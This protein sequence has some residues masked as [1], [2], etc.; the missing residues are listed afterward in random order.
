VVERDAVKEREEMMRKEAERKA[1]KTGSKMHAAPA[2]AAVKTKTGTPVVGASVT[3]AAPAV[4][5]SL[6]FTSKVWKKT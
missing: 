4:P 1:K 2:S 5:G 3:P 6:H